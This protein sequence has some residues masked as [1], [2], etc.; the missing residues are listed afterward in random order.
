MKNIFK[1]FL[2]TLIIQ[3]ILFI[4]LY[5]DIFIKFMRLGR[6]VNEVLAML[7]YL[8]LGVVGSDMRS[9]ALL[10]IIGLPLF[11]LTRKYTN[12]SWIVPFLIGFLMEMTNSIIFRLTNGKPLMTLVSFD[13][14]PNLIYP[15]IFASLYWWLDKRQK[16]RLKPLLTV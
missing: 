6:P 2:L 3:N 5:L 7:S 11:K 12:S 10:F 14:I 9:L 15:C 8:F 13:I 1:A 16:R 4:Y